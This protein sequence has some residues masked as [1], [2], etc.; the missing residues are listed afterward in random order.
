KGDKITWHIFGNEKWV[1]TTVAEIYRAPSSQGITLTK[2]SLEKLGYNFKPTA[3]LT[4]EKTN[5]KQE[6]IASVQ[7]T[8]DLVKGWDDLTE[9]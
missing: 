5:G 7:Q 3:V 1:T 6:G 4:P 9:A 8:E 2:S